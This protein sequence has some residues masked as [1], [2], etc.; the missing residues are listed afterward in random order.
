MDMDDFRCFILIYLIDDSP[1][2]T[3]NIISDNKKFK[4]NFF[5]KNSNKTNEYLILIWIKV[6]TK[7]SILTLTKMKFEK[8]NSFPIMCESS[9]FIWICSLVTTTF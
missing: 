2:I 9:E 6:T 8:K 7:I 1:A 3:I 5:P 4:F